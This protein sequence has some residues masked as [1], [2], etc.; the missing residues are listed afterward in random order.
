MNASRAKSWVLLSTGGLLLFFLLSWVGGVRDASASEASFV[1]T[2]KGHLL[3]AKIKTVSLKEVLER[4]SRLA[5]I[6]VSLE[7]SVG[8]ETVTVEFENLPLE[9]GIMRILQGKSYALTYARNPFSK[10]RRVLPKVVAIRVVPEGAG[11]SMDRER[12]DSVILLPGSSETGIP[13]ETLE[14]RMGDALFP[15]DSD[16]GLGLRDQDPRVREAALEMLG[17]GDQPLPVD[18]LAGMVLTDK[19][20]HLRMDAMSLLAEKGGD[21][22]LD[23]LRQ[24]IRDPD[25]GVSGLAMGLLEERKILAEVLLEKLKEDSH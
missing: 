2:L 11:S 9:E 14:G 3:N 4:L 7:K 19:S 8:D 18:S 25:P 20:P 13:T 22:A 17:Q 12:A 23:T 16:K 15:R 21:G 6:E 1:L 10:G 24:A 5:N